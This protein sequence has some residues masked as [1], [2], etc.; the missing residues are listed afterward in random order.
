M[1]NPAQGLSACRTGW[2]YDCAYSSTGTTAVK[3]PMPVA[4][5]NPGRGLSACRTG[6]KYIRHS[7]ASYAFVDRTPPPHLL[8]GL[9]QDPKGSHGTPARVARHHAKPPGRFGGIGVLQV[10]IAFTSVCRT[11][12]GSGTS[13]SFGAL[14]NRSWIAFAV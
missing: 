2:K 6:W 4:A 9:Q 3:C 11:T 7:N 13:R 14:K 10:A 8:D 5:D 1:N 12:P